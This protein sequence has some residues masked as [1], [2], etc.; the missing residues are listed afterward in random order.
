MA[1]QLVS[2]RSMSAPTL[3]SSFRIVLAV[4]GL[5]QILYEF[6]DDAERLLEI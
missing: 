4:Q 5:L 2:V 1:L 3:F 6:S